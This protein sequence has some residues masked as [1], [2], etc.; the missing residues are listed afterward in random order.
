MI[1]WKFF[2]ILLSDFF[3]R[4]N[5]KNLGISVIRMCMTRN[6]ITCNAFVWFSFFHVNISFVYFLYIHSFLWSIFLSDFFLIL[7]V[8]S[9]IKL[10]I[11][12]SSFTLR[13]IINR[14]KII[15]VSAVIKCVCHKSI[16]LEQLSLLHSKFI[17]KL[18]F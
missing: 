6:K 11:K 15:N 10:V 7:K 1:Y 8:I 9:K 2:Y 13:T 16:F 4:D 5:Q 18:N 3:K 14:R 17:L 12:L